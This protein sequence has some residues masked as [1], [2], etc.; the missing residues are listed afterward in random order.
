M[1][2]VTDNAVRLPLVEQE[3]LEWVPPDR[4]VIANHDDGLDPAVVSCGQPWHVF[5]DVGL[6]FHDR[7]CCD[8]TNENR[9]LRSVDRNFI[10]P[11]T[12]AGD[13]VLRDD[14][15]AL[16][17]TVQDEVYHDFCLA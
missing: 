5:E 13:A 3:L 9:P 7:D 14:E 16:E 15:N 12:S 11:H 1:A 4:V 10:L 17:S 2:F 6:P 8:V